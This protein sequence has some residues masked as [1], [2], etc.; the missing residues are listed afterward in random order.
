VIERVC[1]FCGSGDGVP[2]PYLETA[3]AVGRALAGSGVTVVYGGGGTGLMGAVADGALELGGRVIGIMPRLFDTPALRHPRVID[4]RL[5]DSMPE[6]MAMMAEVSEAFVALPGGF[7]TM[8]E[9]FEVLT[10][11]QLGLH[12]RPVALL[13][14]NGYYAQL[15]AW[16]ERAA[17]EGFIYPEHRRLFMCVETPESLLPALE[18]YRRPDGL[19]RWISRAEADR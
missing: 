16:M 17:A 15:L 8:E 1:V 19:E 11:A 6:R 14:V 12:A 7:G 18:A 9:F 4:L 10:S 2:S 5:V 13:N 3:R